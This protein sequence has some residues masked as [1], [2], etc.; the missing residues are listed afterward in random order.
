M[1]LNENSKPLGDRVLVEPTKPETKKNG[2]ILIET[3]QKK[4]TGKVILI[5]VKTASIKIGDSV[6]YQDNAGIS[7]PYNG[8]DCLLLSE[9][10]E[11]ISIL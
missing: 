3:A 9:E 5:G 11:V 7:I 1:E 8:M 4:N 6:L 2:I 10:H